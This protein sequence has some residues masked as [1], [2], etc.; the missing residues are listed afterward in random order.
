MITHFIDP[1]VGQTFFGS[2]EIDGVVTSRFQHSNTIYTGQVLADEVHRY[3]KLKYPK[4]VSPFVVS[5]KA[6]EDMII[7]NLH[8]QS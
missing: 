8:T 3:C 6:E 2:T 5:S 4:A 1:Q 7:R